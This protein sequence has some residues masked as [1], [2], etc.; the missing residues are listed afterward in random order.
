MTAATTASGDRDGRVRDEQLEHRVAA[1]RA[2]NR[3]Y[4]KQLGLLRRGYLDSPFSL[5]EARVLYELAQRDETEVAELRRALDLEAGF[6]SRI[7]D[8]FERDDLIRGERSSEDRRRQ[9]VELT[10][11]G[12]AAFRSLDRRSSKELAA[13]LG[14]HP[15]ERQRRLV[16]A[17]GAIRTI[18][19]E[20][21]ERRRVEIRHAGPGDQGWVLERHAH[22]Y[23]DTEGWGEPFVALV[24]RVVADFLDKHDPARERAWIAEVDGERAGAVYCV[25]KSAKVA[26]LRLLFVEPWARGLG[27]GTR[28]VD[29]CIRFAGR[30]GYRRLMLWTNNSLAS[31]RRI[32][33][34]AGFR[35]TKE[36]PHHVFPE[37]TT[38][39]ELWLDLPAE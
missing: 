35:Q 3:F 7:H 19:G 18:L 27:I 29:E 10:G 14:V 12:R 1:V 30:S 33:D 21:L 8:G 31:A 25:R 2:F 17:M 16:E 32:Y 6:P 11:K 9:L 15:E 23:S 38:G 34:A 22:L 39:Q 37:G 20:P 4:T 24:A 26:Q 36:E 5:P 28:L 13:M